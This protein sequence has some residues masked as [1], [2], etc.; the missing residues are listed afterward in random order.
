MRSVSL[1]VLLATLICVGLD[2]PRAG[3]AE[4]DR[5]NIIAILTDDQA[6]WTIGAYG[7][8][9]VQT[10]HLDR[11]AASGARFTNA[12]VATPV[13]SPSR[14]EFFTGLYGT[15]VGITDYLN[16]EEEAAGMG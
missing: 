11:L 9:E 8:P 10:P 2:V 4:P 6:R 14:V 3:A 1:A 16:R 5:P 7:N 15:Q 13:C 12:F